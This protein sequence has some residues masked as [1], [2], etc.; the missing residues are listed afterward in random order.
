LLSHR[1][2][3]T[4]PDI[5]VVGLPAMFSATEWRVNLIYEM[6]PEVIDTARTF[7]RGLERTVA[8]RPAYPQVAPT[9]LDKTFARRPPLEMA[10]YERLVEEA[11]N[12]ARQVSRSRLILMGPGSFN[13]DTHETYERH[14]PTLWSGVNQMLKGLAQRTGCGFIDAQGVLGEHSGEVFYPNNHRFSAFGHEVV[15]REVANVLQAQMP[16]ASRSKDRVWDANA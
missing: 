5:V 10:E 16:G 13:E 6:A 14:D 9:L 8:G 12:H 11:V 1:L 7:M 2:L 15:A 4:K 3:F